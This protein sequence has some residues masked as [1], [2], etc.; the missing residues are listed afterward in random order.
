[1]YA[2]LVTEEGGAQRRLEF[3]KPEVSV[4]RVQGNDIILSKRNV[5][6]NHARIVLNEDRPI[7]VDLNSTNGTWVNGRKITSPFP[8]NDGDKIYIADFILSLEPRLEPSSP[9]PSRSAPTIPASSAALGAGM[10][11]PE[12][13]PRKAESTEA[14]PPAPPPNRRS[15]GSKK[16]VEPKATETHANDAS[17]PPSVAPSPTG[18][19]GA[20]STLMARLDER[21]NAH[22]IEATAMHDESRW[23]VAKVAIAETIHSMQSD[24]SLGATI[25]TRRLAHAALHEAVGL[26]PLDDILSSDS[27]HE[28]V[29]NAPD[30]VLVDAGMGLV[31]AGARFSSRSTL[32]TIARRLAAQTGQML[33]RRPTLRGILT[34]GPHVTILQP[35]LAVQGPILQIRKRRSVSLDELTQKSWMTSEMSAYLRHSIARARN[36]IVVGPRRSGVSTL[37]SALIGEVSDSEQVVTA[38]AMPDL[39]VD[40]SR[41]ISLVAS[42]SGL[43]LGEVIDEAARLRGNRLVL[44]DLSG[45]DVLTGLRA[46]LTRSPGHMLGVH[47][48]DAS[49]SPVDRLALAAACGGVDGDCAARLVGSAAPV[50]VALAVE[51][52][53]PRVDQIVEV[54]GSEG[55]SIVHRVARLEFEAR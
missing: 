34:F 31:P 26:G 13:L 4:G 9:R 30:R 50:V 5:S 40:R 55:N 21:F 47:I 42:E 43:K 14:P 6:K 37:I 11:T 45:P 33:G 32:Q 25:D 53:G 22:D 24:G 2:V 1:M 15:G 38:E 54:Q 35:P 49:S 28:V 52:S 8:L 44:D 39:R 23:S 7:V 17:T 27:V 19:L 46:V 18:A 36:V 20:L 16:G 12:Q 48:W 10:P 41:V 51:A 3:S 29:V